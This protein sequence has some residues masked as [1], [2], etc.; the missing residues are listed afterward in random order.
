MSSLANEF[1]QLRWLCTK[2]DNSLPARKARL[3]KTVALAAAALL[4]NRYGPYFEF[5]LPMFLALKCPGCLEY[6]I[7]N[8]VIPLEDRKKTTERE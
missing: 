5:S 2:F 7:N 6:F 8:I 1:H 4:G 3:N